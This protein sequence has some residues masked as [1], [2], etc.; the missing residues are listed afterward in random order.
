MSRRHSA[1]AHTTHPIIARWCIWS[2]KNQTRLAGQLRIYIWG[3][4]FLVALFTLGGLIPLETALGAVFFSGLVI[5]AALWLLIR[6][7]KVWLLNIQ[8]PELRREALAAMLDYLHEVRHAIPQLKPRARI[9]SQ[10]KRRCIP[11]DCVAKD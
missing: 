3:G 8:G 4:T 11:P 6:Q 7:R 5:C 10:F 1:Q 9:T 2:V